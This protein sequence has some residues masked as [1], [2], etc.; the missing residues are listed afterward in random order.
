MSAFSLLFAT[1][2]CSLLFNE[3][4]PRPLLERLLSP[5]LCLH[6]LSTKLTRK[7][8]FALIRRLCFPCPISRSIVPVPFP[9]FCRYNL[10]ECS[11]CSSASQCV[12]RKCWGG[13]CVYDTQAS[14]DKC[15]T[16]KPECA[17]CTFASQCETHKCWGG[18]CVFDT[19]TSKEKCFKPQ[20]A[21]CLANEEC[22]TQSCHLGKCTNTHAPSSCV[23]FKPICSP[24]KSSHE[25]ITKSCWNGM[26][27]NKFTSTVRKVPV[28]CFLPLSTKPPLL[29]A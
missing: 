5:D 20:C 28:N 10:P 11:H 26:C 4:K 29:D 27:V 17:S 7:S 19:K 12:T 8:E 25:C 15:F 24:C 13:K 22:I 16:G 23:P 14:K 2:L 1:V 9:G 21:S 18:K 6:P 3:G